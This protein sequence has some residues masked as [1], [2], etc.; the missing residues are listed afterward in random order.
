MLSNFSLFPN[1][2]VFRKE[3]IHIFYRLFQNSEEFIVGL[4]QVPAK[5]QS[6]LSHK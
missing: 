5:T 6:L 3:A 2:M 4:Q 1:E